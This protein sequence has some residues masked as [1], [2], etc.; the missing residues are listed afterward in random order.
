MCGIA[1]IVNY[2]SKNPAQME[3]SLRGMTHAIAHR[4]NNGQGFY[5]DHTKSCFLGH[6]RLAIIDLSDAGL[7]PMVS[8]GGRHVIT[9]NGEIYNYQELAAQLPEYQFRTSSDTE[10]LL[11]AYERWGADM[12]G[13]LRGMFAFAI[14]DNV[15]QEL[16]AAVDHCGMKPLYWFYEKVDGQP[17]FLFASELKALLS[18]S[19]V[20][21]AIDPVALR[22]F[23]SF[24]AI[25]QPRTL[26]ADVHAMEPGH[27]LKLTQTGPQIV[28]YWTPAAFA[29]Q[30]QDPYAVQQKTAE[31]VEDAV[32]MHMRADIPVGAFLS[33]G[34]DS[35]T[36]V[37][38]M[39][40]FSPRPIETFSIG[41]E[42]ASVVNELP[43]AKLV[44]Q[45]FGTAHHEV[46]VTEQIFSRSVDEFIT[47]IDQPSGD[48]I[49]SFLVARATANKVS[50]ALSG[51]G[52]DE[53]FLGYRYMQDLSRLW[54]QNSFVTQAARIVTK[55]PGMKS[56]AYRTGNGWLNFVENRS[57][58]KQYFFARHLFSQNE[59][60]RLV[61]NLSGYDGASYVGPIAEL[62]E[63]DSD[64]GNGLSKAELLWYT[65]GTLLRDGD[66]TAMAS[67]LEVRFPFLDRPLIE[68]LLS[69]PS[70]MKIQRNQKVNKPL[71]ANL[72]PDLLPAE[73]LAFPK[74]GF[75]MPVGAWLKNSCAVEL[76]VL[77]KVQWL[78][79]RYVDQLLQR[80]FADPR[81][82]LPVWSLFVLIRWLEQYHG[83]ATYAKDFIHSSRD[84]NWWG[85]SQSSAPRSFAR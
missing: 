3:Q 26:L 41:F 10:V 52:G 57:P 85:G 69:V 63:K 40:R 68:Y 31:M 19:F 73:I 7:Q 54:Q 79:Q 23:L 38:L 5:T 72:F 27:Y 18:C 77:K 6:R 32:R 25:N 36:I 2:Q 59:I 13:K 61:P 12:L 42:T 67:T 44:A 39:T 4:G 34:I 64:W 30:E 75:E 56:V 62:F 66:A 48:G 80:F 76:L 58:A 84:R 55:I 1:G 14:W 81:Y 70:A 78:D 24:Y 43:L 16:F 60:D 45:K 46:M 82:Y 29:T 65:S 51:L 9:F 22:N 8:N 71:L 28:R 53:V 21:R 47:A 20:S 33:G 49:N 74:Q 17:V 50:V 37:G 35:S 83:E 11:A 15:T